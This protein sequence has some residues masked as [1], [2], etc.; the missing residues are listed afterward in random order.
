MIGGPGLVAQAHLE[1]AAPCLLIA[2]QAAIEVL[3]QRLEYCCSLHF[4]IEAAH[5]LA[6]VAAIVTIL[7]TAIAGMSGRLIDGQEISC[8]ACLALYYCCHFRGFFYR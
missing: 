6:G 8:I 4:S 2:I 7:A 5:V 1:V 3:A